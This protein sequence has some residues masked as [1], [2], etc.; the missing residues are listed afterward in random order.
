MLSG[1][2]NWKGNDKPKVTYSETG[3]SERPWERVKEWN[4]W[5][6]LFIRCGMSGFKNDSALCEQ[7]SHLKTAKSETAL[8]LRWKFAVQ[9]GI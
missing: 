3:G 8:T 5:W 9:F 2:V 1:Y 4:G 7:W 6:R